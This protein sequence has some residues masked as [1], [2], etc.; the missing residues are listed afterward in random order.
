MKLNTSLT[1][2]RVQHGGN[3]PPVN[4]SRKV[5]TINLKAFCLL[6][7]AFCLLLAIAAL[8]LSCTPNSNH[9]NPAAVQPAQSEIK[10]TGAS[11]PYPAMKILAAAYGT[12][13]NNSDITFLPSSQSA[14]GIAGVKSGLADIGTLTRKLKSGEDDGSL[15]YRELARDALVVATHPSVARVTN[16]S[17]EDLKAIY[18]GAVTNWQELGGP[19]AK[20]VVL[21]RPED[22]SAKRLLRQVMLA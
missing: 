2:A 17:T 19:D 9:H 1:V 16:L 8:S 20:I 21:D 15:V 4:N 14:S 13:A 7:S 5:D 18:S 6:P 22:E 11:T 12:N 3:K 10:V